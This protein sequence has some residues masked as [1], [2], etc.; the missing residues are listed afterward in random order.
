[1]VGEVD[2][3]IDRADER[4]RSGLEHRKFAGGGELAVGRFEMGATGEHVDRLHPMFDAEQRQR[5]SHRVAPRVER[6]VVQHWDAHEATTSRADG[7]ESRSSCSRRTRAFT[8]SAGTMP[9]ATTCTAVVCA[10]IVWMPAITS[11][12]SIMPVA[13]A[14]DRSRP[15]RE[16][17]VPGS[18]SIHTDRTGVIAV[19]GASGA[20]PASVGATHTNPALSTVRYCCG[21]TVFGGSI[22]GWAGTCLHAPAPSNC[23]P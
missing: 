15:R 2:E 20:S 22:R 19:S 11:V 14:P 3:D 17:A 18:P 5:Q 8:V 23:H 4:R 9:A 13:T 10:S 6:E 1:S 16:R 12:P 7:T 21:F